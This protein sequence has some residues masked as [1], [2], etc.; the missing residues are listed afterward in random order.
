MTTDTPD[1]WTDHVRPARPRG[2]SA[3]WQG[4]RAWWASRP[5]PDAASDELVDLRDAFRRAAE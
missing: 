3:D 1:H 4:A 2:F 5:R